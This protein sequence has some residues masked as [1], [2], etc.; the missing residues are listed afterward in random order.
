MSISKKNY[1]GRQTS[2]K[3]K[4]FFLHFSDD[5][6]QDHG[7]VVEAQDLGE[8]PVDLGRLLDLITDVNLPELL[9][10]AQ[11]R[12]FQLFTTDLIED[13]KNYRGVA[14]KGGAVAEWFKALK[15]R[16]NIKYHQKGPRLAPPPGLGNLQI[17]AANKRLH[18]FMFTESHWVDTRSYFGGS[19]ARAL[20][21]F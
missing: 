8:P 9:K 1:L 4:K 10:E 5:D 20:L 19:R 18:T 13:K 16:E 11:Q 21:R 15:L 14:D 3:V 17:R 12:Q 6:S 2:K 7:L